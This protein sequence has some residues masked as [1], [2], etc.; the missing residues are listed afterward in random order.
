M[1]NRLARLKRRVV[2]RRLPHAA[3]GLPTD[4]QVEDFLQVARQSFV[5]LQAAWDAADLR[6]L[7]ALTTDQ[8][9]AELQDQL[10][11]RG[12]GPNR[13]EVLKLDARLLG[14]EEL[15]EAFVASVEFSGLIRERLDDG[16]APFRE[17]WLLANLKSA[18]RGWQLARVQALG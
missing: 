11:A 15:Q 8:L 7:A 4:P 1:L 13:T 16:A 17:L 14:I 12:P 9:L 5:R 18:G 6:A 10:A 3:A 2:A